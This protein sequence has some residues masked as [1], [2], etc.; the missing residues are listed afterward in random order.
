MESDSE[1][2]SRV[3]DLAERS[4]RSGTVTHT[5]FLTPKEQYVLERWLKSRK[6]TRYIIGSGVENTERNLI[7]FYP[8][9]MDREEAVFSE[10][11]CGVGVK[12][13]FGEPGHRDYLGSVLGLG[14]K[15]EWIGDILINGDQGYII[16]LKSVQDTL[17][18]ELTHISRYGVKTSAV[19]LDMI[20]S[21]KTE[22]QKKTFTVQSMRLDSITAS[23]FNISRSKVV[24]YIKEGLVTLNYQE[25]L[26]PGKE[27]RE[28]DIIS[29]RGYGKGVT[30]SVK[31][32]SKK[33]RI[34]VE[35][36]V[37]S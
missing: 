37:Y 14:I 8:E 15:R 1:L 11:V 34:I 3:E 2:F 24:N 31:G 9:W 27:I 23:A 5:H 28:G 18:N 17:L 21:K 33:G 16:C 20:P 10:F 6:N 7:L 26:T 4:D 30:S 36:D 29:V 35:F 12:V 32:M 22:V 19:S 25:C 13:G